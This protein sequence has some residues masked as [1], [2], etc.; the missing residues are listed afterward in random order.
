[1]NMTKKSEENSD[2][3][4]VK[5]F[6]MMLSSM[7]SLM[8]RLGKTF[9]RFRKEALKAEKI[10]KKELINQGIDK[11][12]AEELSKTYS[13]GRKISNIFQKFH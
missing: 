9:L 5:I 6:G 8:F 2:E 1:M 11:N 7:P 3:N 13:E 10:F 4:P 12:I